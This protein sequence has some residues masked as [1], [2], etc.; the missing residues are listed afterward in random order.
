[1]FTALAAGASLL[2]TGL[3][4]LEVGHLRGFFQGARWVD[5]PI[6]W[7]IALGAGLLA[8]GRH[9]SR[10]LGP[11]GWTVVRSPRQRAI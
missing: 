1:M 4:G 5:P 8:L 11:L 7:Q 2:V 10:R 6:W 3:L 9:W